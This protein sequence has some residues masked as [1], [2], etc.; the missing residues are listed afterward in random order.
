MPE[1]Q[2]LDCLVLGAGISGLDAA[3]HLQKH[4]PWANY[5][6]LER[7][8]NLGGTWDFFKYPGIRSD[9]DM[10]TFGFSWKIWRSAKPIATAEEILAYLKEAAE[11]QGIGKKI[12][13]NTNVESASWNSA[14]NRWH[15]VTSGGERFSCKM[16]FGCT[17]YYSYETPYQPTFPG[18]DDFPGP[19]VHPQ[20]WTSE[21]DK[22]IQGKRVALIGSG[23]TAVTILPNIAEMAAHVTMVQRT[24]TYIAAK[25]EIDPVVSFL[26]K[27]LPESI[28][29][30]LNRLKAVV[31]GALFYQYCVRYPQ[32]AKKLVQ[33]GMFKEV[34]VVMSRQ[35]F[36][37][38]FTPPYNPW[39]QRFCLAPDG[40]FFAPLREGK[41]TM[42]TGHIDRFTT[43]GILM[44]S[45]ERVEADFI[46]SATGLTMQRNFPFSTVRVSVD[47]QEYKATDHIIY[48]G[49]MVSDVPNF[50]FIMGYTN[51]SWTLKA[52]IASLYFTK[53]LNHMRKHEVERVMPRLNPKDGIVNEAFDG[54]LSSGY[55]ARAQDMLPKQGD[56]FP[57]KGG[58]NYILDLL[59]QSLWGLSKDSLEFTMSD[60]KGR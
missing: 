37:K 40:D 18:Q 30:R 36:E 4:C 21:H 35:E 11:E 1:E 8:A 14:D 15:L 58:V 51:A 31:L 13:F 60:K 52:D 41:A 23:A 12:M 26:N 54:G 6:I 50:A 48:N 44:K 5:A 29:V 56:K 16:L 57:W 53:L 46:I 47:G 42:V 32:H 20:K 17:G 43:D 24:P 27:W 28:A 39:D 9:S 10:Y 49:I 19:I 55:F 2:H 45:G 7:R 33:G 25:P 59:R 3:F 22:M 38:H 34:K